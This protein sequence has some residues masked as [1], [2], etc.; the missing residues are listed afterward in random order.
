Q[1]QMAILF[2]K[3]VDTIGLHIKNIYK[4][5]EL[6]KKATSEESSVVRLEGS[7]NVTR[8]IM[9]YNL[10]VIISVGYRVNSIRG[11]QFRIWATNV[12]RNHLLNGYSVNRHKIEA[13]EYKLDLL[14]K[15]LKNNNTDINVIKA[16]LNILEED[17]LFI[18]KILKPN[19]VVNNYIDNK[20]LVEASKQNSADL[21]IKFNE[22]KQILKEIENKLPKTSDLRGLIQD[23]QDNSKISKENP[24]AQTKLKT[25]IKE[26]SSNDSSIYILLTKAGIAKDII[27]KVAELGLFLIRNLPF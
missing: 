20:P 23:I 5:S 2:D 19:F 16:K 3:D 8:K 1:A 17:Q 24:K 7:R 10:D 22:L 12:L 11:T 14:I 6:N 26:L 18:R 9:A 4:T 15:E 27:T 25:F 13:V 21:G